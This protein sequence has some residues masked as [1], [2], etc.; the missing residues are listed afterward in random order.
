MG[1]VGVP[2]RPPRLHPAHGYRQ[3]HVRGEPVQTEQSEEAEAHATAR[4]ANLTVSVGR[5][6][7]SVCTRNFLHRDMLRAE[8]SA[9]F[10]IA[11]RLLSRVEQEK[12]SMFIVPVS[13]QGAG[14]RGTRRV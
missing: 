5:G 12:M 3:Q 14:R 7:V 9:Q 6:T 1:I 8:A 13:G 10:T 2:R 11:S 4:S